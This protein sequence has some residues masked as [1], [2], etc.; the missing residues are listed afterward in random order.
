MNKLP[1]ASL[2]FV[3]VMPLAAQVA[4]VSQISGV[5]LDSTGA[6]VPNAR[7]TITNVDTSAS[8]TV[9]SAAD[10][11]Y[12]VTNL[13]AGPY[14]LQV[15]KSGFATYSQA[16]IV[17]QV[18]TNPTINVTL[19]VGA[20]TETVEV[21]ANAALVE[22]QNNTI[23]SVMDQQRI[24]ELPLNGRNAAQLVSLVGAAVA[25]QPG[26]IVN[27][28]NHPGVTAVSVAG[29][30]GNATNFFLDGGMHL[31]P[32]T[33]VGLP[34]PF[35][36]SLQE[37]KVETS[38]LPANYGSHPGGAVNVVTKSGTNTLHGNA[39]YF[40]R[41]AEFNA[42][43]VL[44]NRVDPLKRNQFGGTLG[45]PI[46]RDKV[47]V[48]G[49][50]QANIERTAPPTIVSFV[51]TAAA[52]QGDFRTLLSPP[53]QAAPR[54]LLPVTGAV[55][56]VVPLTR[57]NPVAMKFV[58][59]IPV[60]NDPCGRLQYGVVSRSNEYQGVTRIDW[61]RTANDS[62][63]A[64]Y[65]VTDYGL[66]AYYDKSNLLT[67]ASPG[68]RDRVQSFI[69]GD[70]YLISPRAVNSFRASF[71]RSAVQRIG[72]DGVPTMAQLGSNV[73]SPI[74]NYTG[75]IQISGYFNTGA[76]PGHIYN[77]IYGLSDDVAMTRGAHQLAFGFNWNQ[78]QMNALGPFQMNPRM[79]FSGQLAGNALAGF[80]TG[81]MDTILQGNGQVGRDVQRLPALYI[82]DNW[83]VRRRFQLNFGVRWDPF[84][85]QYSKYG[86]AARFDPGKFASGEVSK[87]FVN[88]PPGVSFIGD[89][90][91][92]GR[93]NTRALYKNFA[94]RI[95]FVYDPRGQ[96]RETIRAA[97]GI[98]YDGTFLWNTMHVTLNPPW[99]NTITLPAP[100]NLSDPW[101]VYPGGKPFPTAP[102]SSNYAFPTAG[103]FKFQPLDNHATY[104][105]QWNVAL[106]K[107]MGADW[108][109][110][111]TYLG[112]KTTHQWLGYQANY[113]P[114]I[115]GNCTAGQYGLTAAGP[116]S[117][118]ANINARR[119]YTVARPTSG[120]Q[121]LGDTIQVDDGGNASYNALLLN[122]QHRMSRH[123][124]ANTNYT[125]SHCLNQGEANQDIASLYQNPANRRAEW[126]NCT[127]DRRHLFNTSLVVES[128]AYSSKW[129][130]LI[131]GNWRGSGIFTAYSGP[132]LTITSGTDRSLTGIG[133]DR[134][135]VA[136]D[137][138]VE[139]NTLARFFN[140]AAFS[141]NAT[142]T[143]GTVGRATLRGRA[144][145]NLDA[146]IFRSFS[147][148][149]RLKA[150]LRLEAFNALNHARFNDPGTN[151]N[152]GTT[153][154]VTT[155][156][157]DPRIMQVA[158]KVVF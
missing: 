3:L 93:S 80:M 95:G 107:Q 129:M 102:P 141:A 63:F 137:W 142:G 140:P 6:A 81:V 116:C 2:L 76:I 158:M 97:Y 151:L 59:L 31:D 48:F 146:A 126:G 82:Q 156:A 103:T 83:K 124:S 5:V 68:L 10:G 1:V 123:F 37:F 91:F 8:R 118:L 78:I 13:A 120:G 67:A 23:G 21:Q 62:I 35:P 86:Y 7:I 150:D 60:S 75:Q 79:T 29:G 104:V 132:S 114:Y 43:N 113:A 65:F 131:V 14:R 112:N 27:T 128:P 19:R 25:S 101:S 96:G 61:Q 47:F 115:A 28:L 46:V 136:G 53:C 98:F 9:E 24:L 34:L 44:A 119:L 144:N 51:P 105:Q 87:V 22:T 72:A 121:Y 38:T 143:F 41:N 52:L 71:S 139:Q 58:S 109:V 17:L 33:N 49:A 125:W 135:N 30:Q 152:N 64:R 20:V 55:N 145:W 153:F 110:S 4:A 147:I 69:L 39:F 130:R 70:T 85:P 111:A 50:F 92:P 155:T 99:G 56:N 88:A 18:S 122:M 148:T 134:P 108:F 12:V 42:K 11:A 54:T 77:N 15:S 100:G 154:G 90:G 94:P 73:Y 127:S 66:Q 89:A 36:D 45:G 133:N 57:L 157:L 117:S 138:R 149:E 84:V 74:P 16:G 106:Q 26:G 32:R 40:V